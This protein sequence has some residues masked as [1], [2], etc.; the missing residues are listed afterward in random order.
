MAP[1]SGS[2]LLRVM[3]HAFH[4]LPWAVSER[5]G[6]D[7][8]P[9][10]FGGS[11]DQKKNEIHPDL[12]RK[13]RLFWSS[14][15]TRSFFVFI[16]LQRN[17]SKKG[18]LKNNIASWYH[19]VPGEGLRGSEAGFQ[20]ASAGMSKVSKNIAFSWLGRANPCKTIAFLY[21]SVNSYVF[22]LARHHKAKRGRNK[23][24]DEKV[25]GL[26]IKLTHLRSGLRAN[27]AGSI[28]D[29]DGVAQKPEKPIIFDDI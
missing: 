17:A 18:R 15:N 13:C 5:T 12:L 7:P 21:V 19:G 11:S 24:S 3:A 23:T 10:R 2:A 1:A 28:F 8:F 9:L 27:L 16:R 14:V 4:G 25:S 26:T 20:R 22:E 6:S 29:L